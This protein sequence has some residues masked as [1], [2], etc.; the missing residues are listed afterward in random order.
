MK[1][2]KKKT[3]DFKLLV[4]T[5]GRRGTKYLSLKS[6]SCK[7]LKKFN[8]KHVNIPTDADGGHLSQQHYCLLKWQINQDT[9]LGKVK[10]WHPFKNRTS[11]ALLNKNES[12]RNLTLDIWGGF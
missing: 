12:R 1:K 9:S 7:A 2:K 5:L 4:L 8:F 10:K 11:E 6:Q 3:A